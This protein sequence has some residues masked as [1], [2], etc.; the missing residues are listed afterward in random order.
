LVA[1]APAC[2]IPFGVRKSDSASRQTL[3]IAPTSCTTTIRVSAP[4]PFRHLR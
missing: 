4:L 1:P 2:C 3:S